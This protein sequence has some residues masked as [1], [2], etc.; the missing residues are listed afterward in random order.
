MWSRRGCVMAPV[1]LQVP[2]A[3]AAGTLKSSDSTTAVTA[4]RSDLERSRVL[5]IAVPPQTWAV[6]G[7][8]APGWVLGLW[9]HSRE[10]PLRIPRRRDRYLAPL[11]CTRGVPSRD[12]SADW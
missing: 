2:P 1:E 9:R 8:P 7:R 5:V 11:H 10:R 6:H 3:A 4:A 12:T